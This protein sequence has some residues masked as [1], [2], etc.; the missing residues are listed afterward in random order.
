MFIFFE[1]HLFQ[2]SL[3]YGGKNENKKWGEKKVLAKSKQSTYECYR[4]QAHIMSPFK[5]IQCCQTDGK[6]ALQGHWQTASIL[7]LPVSPLN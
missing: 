2:E 6:Y 3:R 7:D 5:L 4:I 1:T